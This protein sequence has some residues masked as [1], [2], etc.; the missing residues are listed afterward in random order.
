MRVSLS[1]IECAF[2]ISSSY[3]KCDLTKPEHSKNYD[4]IITCGS[5]T[6]FSFF[7]LRLISAPLLL[8]T[9]IS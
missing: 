1:V 3:L 7:N 8:K 9:K 4:A 2:T 6:Q 5:N